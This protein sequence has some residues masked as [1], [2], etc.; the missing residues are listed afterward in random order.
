MN[1]L[2]RNWI[3]TIFGILMLAM[4]CLK[5]VQNPAS[6]SD[7]DTIALIGGGAGLIAAKD[8]NK[9]GVAPVDKQ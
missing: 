4:G 9:T 8:G 1:N 2:K 7:P 3:T 6:A 5:I